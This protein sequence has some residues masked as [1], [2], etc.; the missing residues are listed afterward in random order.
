MPRRCDIS[1]ALET[2]TR[3]IFFSK[4]SPAGSFAPFPNELSV[5][6]SD[7]M[8][9]TDQLEIFPYDIDQDL[10]EIWLATSRFCGLVNRA[11]KSKRRFP[12]AT[13]LQVITSVMYRLLHLC[14]SALSLNEAIR[15][16]LLAF[17]SQ[18]FLQLP[19]LKTDDTFLRNAFWE[20]LVNISTSWDESPRFLLWL[21]M[22]GAVSVSGAA[23]HVSLGPLLR[24]SFQKCGVSSWSG[25]LNVMNSMVWIGL[26]FDKPGERVYNS[27]MV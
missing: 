5:F 20:C 19:N 11:R 12:E 24:T 1:I 6:R 22:I 21:Q 7:T 27:V 10:A 16:A 23:D 9:R 15:L 2:G 17:C 25:L 26:V 14:F 8:E 3:P 13:L 18:T 4:T